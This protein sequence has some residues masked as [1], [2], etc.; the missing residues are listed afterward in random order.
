MKTDVIPLDIVQQIFASNG[1]QAT[2][3]KDTQYHFDF[4]GSGNVDNTRD[5]SP[6]GDDKD[7]NRIKNTDMSIPN[8][9]SHFVEIGEFS[10]GSMFGLG[11]HMEDRVIVAKQTEVQCLLIPQYWLFQKKQNAGNIWQR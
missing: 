10:C 8:S 4:I 1:S 9:K 11:E 6:D 5:T 2:N 3:L 7:E